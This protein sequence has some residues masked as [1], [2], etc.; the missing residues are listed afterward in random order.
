MSLYLKR[1]ANAIDASKAPDKNKVINDLR[2][3][4]AGVNPPE[5]PNPKDVSNIMDRTE[6]LL[7]KVNTPAELTRLLKEIINRSAVNENMLGAV[8]TEVKKAIKL[9]PV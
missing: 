5:D 8:L 2:R 1:M 3:L 7:P 9:P 6:N 4:I